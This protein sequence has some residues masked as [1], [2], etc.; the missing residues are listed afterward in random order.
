MI[1]YC[2]AAISALLLFFSI[3]NYRDAR[4]VADDVLFG[5]AHSIHAAIEFSIENDPSMHS[6]SHFHA[7]DVVFFGLVDNRGIYR[8][9]T[10]PKRIGTRISDPTMM[11]ELQSETMTGERIR[12]PG[13]EEGYQLLTHVH[14]HGGTLGLRLVMDTKRADVIIRNAR[15]N[16]VIMVTLLIVSWTLTALVFHYVLQEETR[17]RDMA[18]FEY[19]AK[20]GEMGA[21]L[22][23]E[24][25]NP[26]AGIKGFAELIERRSDTPQT[27]DSAH[28]ILTET[29]RLENLTTDLLALARSERIERQS[30]DLTAL[31]GQTM[32]M[33]HAEAA[34]LQVT[35]DIDCPHPVRVPGD[36]D[37]LAQVLLNIARNGLQAMT[38]GG[39]LRI[40]TRR[41]GQCIE[42]RISDTGHGID[43]ETMN[44]IFEPFFTTKA[45]GTG[46]GLA[47]CQKIV[48]EHG[49]SID[50]DSSPNGT[51]VIISLPGADTEETA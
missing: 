13:G 46:L 8:F 30:V 2:I 25:R 6:L 47:I 21:L 50:L 19:L 9:H 45:R 38:D 35:V 34:S 23:H 31:I 26:L 27:R 41:S 14:A 44:R 51:T 11:K 16:M 20:L 48:T 39:R 22:A 1:V 12:L 43:R 28:R 32:E 15:A 37:R 42:I 10:D 5:L 17:K 36:R 3:K 7:N 18:K 29:L 49:G 4:P 40:A 24:L 33:V